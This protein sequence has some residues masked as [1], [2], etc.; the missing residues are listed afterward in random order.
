MSQMTGTT[1]GV[2]PT[3]GAPLER[4][5]QP[6]RTL[7]KHRRI[8]P[9]LF[10]IAPLAL[11]ITFTF[12]PAANLIWYSFTDWDGAIARMRTALDEAVTRGNTA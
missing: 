1:G 8:T 9:Y 5:T 3:A 11:L 6:S 10:L 12:V 2:P 4:E 7:T